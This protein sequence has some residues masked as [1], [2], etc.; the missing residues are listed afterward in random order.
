MDESMN[1]KP[2][3]EGEPWPATQRVVIESDGVGVRVALGC[4]L[5]V[6]EGLLARGLSHVQRELLVARLLES[7]APK[8][9]LARTVPRVGGPP[10]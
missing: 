8:V 6:A 9:E 5:A 1:G 10:L 3:G 4:P 2:R 7:A